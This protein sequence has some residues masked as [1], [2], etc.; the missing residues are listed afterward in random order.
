VWG[1]W[2][3]IERLLPLQLIAVLKTFEIPNTGNALQER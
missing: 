2:K 1:G 3:K